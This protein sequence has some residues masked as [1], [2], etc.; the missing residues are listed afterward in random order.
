MISNDRHMLNKFKVNFLLSRNREFKSPSTMGL[1]AGIA[2][3]IVT[4]YEVDN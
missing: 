3:R 1:G 2:V 4:D